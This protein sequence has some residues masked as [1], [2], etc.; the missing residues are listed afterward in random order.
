MILTDEFTLHVLYR[1]FAII[2]CP[3]H[4]SSSFPASCTLHD[5]PHVLDNHRLN[6]PSQGLF[7]A[8][9]NFETNREQDATKE[10]RALYQYY[11]DILD[12]HE[13]IINHSVHYQKNS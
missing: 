8:I 3:L 9:D 11:T 13:L 10:V 7:K 12:V 6:I 1:H 2:P 5:S 4:S